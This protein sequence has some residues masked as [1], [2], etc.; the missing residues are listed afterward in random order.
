MAI[1][2]PLEGVTII[3]GRA[4]AASRTTRPDVSNPL[5]QNRTPSRE[6]T[7]A[8]LFAFHSLLG[9][10]LAKDGRLR[11]LYGGNFR[12]RFFVGRLR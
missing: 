2:F 12:V 9:G 5:S 6:Q 8:V 3:L 11:T 4:E 10:V 7:Y 1:P